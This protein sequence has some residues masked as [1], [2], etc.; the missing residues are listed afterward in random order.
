MGFGA[1]AVRF[2]VATDATTADRTVDAVAVLVEAA[3]GR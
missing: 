1:T 2:D 3:L